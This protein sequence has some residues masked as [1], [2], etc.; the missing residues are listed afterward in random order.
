[1]HIH[2]YTCRGG[3]GGQASQA[4]I[5]LKYYKTTWRNVEA[6]LAKTL[7]TTLHS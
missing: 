2:G 6:R 4:K 5:E 1:M 7:L 3:E